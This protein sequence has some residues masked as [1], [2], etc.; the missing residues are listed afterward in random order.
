MGETCTGP[1]LRQFYAKRMGSPKFE[2]TPGESIYKHCAQ[3]FF[4]NFGDG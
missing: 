3:N 2:D 4:F 1:F